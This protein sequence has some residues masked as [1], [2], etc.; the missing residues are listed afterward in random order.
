M[1]ALV[2]F[3]Y[4][5]ELFTNVED[6]KRFHHRIFQLLLKAL[7]IQK[8]YGPKKTISENKSNLCDVWQVQHLD[9]LDFQ[10][11]EIRRTNIFRGCSHFFLYFLKCFGD[12]YGVYGSKIEVKHEKCRLMVIHANPSKL[13]VWVFAL[14]P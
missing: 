8:V 9:F 12:K 4:V 6:L 13:E 5:L 10:N 2:G 7:G 1:F 14:L 3:T 11:V